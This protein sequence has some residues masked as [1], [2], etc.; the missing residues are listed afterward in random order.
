VR[1]TQEKELK[2]FFDLERENP[3]SAPSVP[4]YLSYLV[5]EEAQIT[6]DSKGL[7]INFR[8]FNILIK[9]AQRGAFLR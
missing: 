7:E 9:S 2:F 5:C 3:K 8:F 1:M 4:G 6:E